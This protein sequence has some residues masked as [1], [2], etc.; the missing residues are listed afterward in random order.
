M[1]PLMLARPEILALQGYSS[2]RLEAGQAAVM[3]N[4]NE[5]PWPPVTCADV[6]LADLH[7]YPDPQPAALVARLAELHEVQPESV[8]VSRGSDEGIDLLV[9]A[10]CRAGQ[11]AI[12]IAPPTFGM[13]AV[14][15]G[16]QGAACI[17]MPVDA[18]FGIDVERVAA[19]LPAPVKLVFL[20]SPNNPTGTLTGLAAI[21]RLARA[22]RTRALLV[23]DE[24]YIEFADSPSATRLL[25]EHVNLV[26]LRTL[27]KAHALAGARVGCL[28]AAPPVIGLLRKIMPPYP[29]PAP[30]V[31][32]ALAALQ[33]SAVA[34]TRARIATLIGE[35]ERMAKALRAAGFGVLPSRAN[36]LCVCF[37][38]AARTWRELLAAGVLVRDV[39]RQR[40]LA[41]CLRIGIGTSEDN[42]RVLDALGVTEGVA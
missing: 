1:N 29:L 40:G 2:A 17:E 37:D 30:S 21:E 25:G 42:A 16:I 28:L 19:R 8:L 11:D 36:F 31:A 13:Y 15:A 34:V 26:V 24:A 12:A 3:L 22:L 18:G 7:R 32:A 4:A 9:R 14:C 27:S 35:R 41:N 20:C 38:E 6:A 10:F 5:S 33:P 39:G 23:V